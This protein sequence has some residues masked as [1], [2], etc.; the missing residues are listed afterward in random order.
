MVLQL[1]GFVLKAKNQDTAVQQLKDN[2]RMSFRTL[3]HHT[4]R[5]GAKLPAQ[6]KNHT[7]SPAKGYP[8]QH[9]QTAV[10]AF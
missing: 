8:V 2:E 4:M 9:R 5:Q 7:H 1:F 10:A 6:L 3:C